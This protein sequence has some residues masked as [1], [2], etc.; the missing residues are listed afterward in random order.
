MNIDKIKEYCISILC[1]I[2]EYE[3][4]QDKGRINDIL[5]ELEQQTDFINRELQE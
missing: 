3:N 2:K 5:I 4:T 1:L